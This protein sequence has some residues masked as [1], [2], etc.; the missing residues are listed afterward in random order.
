LFFG[1]DYWNYNRSMSFVSPTTGWLAND[2]GRLYRTT[3]G[4]NWTSVKFSLANRQIKFIDA[5][6]GWL[7]VNEKTGNRVMTT[8]DGGET[9]QTRLEAPVSELFALSMDLAW[10][11]GSGGMFR[12]TD[13]GATWTASEGDI[14]RRDL[15]FLDEKTGWA[16]D[17]GL[18]RTSNGGATWT[19]ESPPLPTSVYSNIT[20]AC[21]ADARTGW[22]AGMHGNTIYHLP[23]PIRGILFKATGV[24]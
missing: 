8:A 6:S 22:V 1:I 18:W 14:P 16:V 10:V 24:D 12:T 2:N 5:Q 4:V 21:F 23:Y 7:V 9:W 20:A 3:D 15:F 19:L 11:A 17:Q 13:G